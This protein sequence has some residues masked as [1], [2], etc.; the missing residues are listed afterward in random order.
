MNHIYINTVHS[1][2]KKDSKDDDILPIERKTM[3]KYQ[4]NDVI[5]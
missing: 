5:L 1:L 2:K 3:C 4:T